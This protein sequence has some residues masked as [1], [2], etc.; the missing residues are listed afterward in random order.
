MDFPYEKQFKTYLLHQRFLAENTM[1]DICQDV[2]RLF[3]HLRGF[4]LSYR[5]NPSLSNIEEA[6][7]LD[8]LNMLQVKREIKNSTYNKVLTHLN[9]YFEFIFTRRLSQTLPTAGIKG[10]KKEPDELLP[11]TWAANLEPLLADD[12][13]SFYTRMTL[14]C[15]AHFYTITEII[16][17][18]FYQVLAKED[19]TI[20]E[21]NFLTNYR[22]QME[23]LQNLQD[24]H[25]LFLKQRINLADPR[26]TLP[27]L[28]KY[29]KKDQPKIALPLKPQKL[30]QANLFHYLLN[31]QTL[32][33]KD[34]CA[35]LRL[36]PASLNYYRFELAKQK[37]D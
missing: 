8:Y 31:H 21:Q 6:D 3:K 9:I 10:L 19:F 29:F 1:N 14:L 26:L 33:D 7:I 13:I 4:N 27:A 22:T 5:T 36:T 18:D 35:R 24:C 20:A 32:P 17:K 2:A 11:L 16:Q 15:L 28:H 23:H 25:D 34:L 12:S 37:L 30:Y